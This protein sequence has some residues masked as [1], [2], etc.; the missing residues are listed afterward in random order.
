M[1][2][3]ITLICCHSLSLIVIRCYSSSL[4]VLLV[5]IRCHSLSLRV[6]LSLSLFINDPS[7]WRLLLFNLFYAITF[8]LKI[9]IKKGNTLIELKYL[10]FCSSADLFDF[11]VVKFQKKFDKL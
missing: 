6:S 7:F 11:K 5:V 10:P 8:Q 2:P 3:K 9:E 1:K 4:V